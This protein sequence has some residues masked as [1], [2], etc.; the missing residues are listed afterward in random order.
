MNKIQKKNTYSHFTTGEFAKLCNVKKQTLFH[1]D[2][3]GIFSPEIKTNNGYRYYSYRQL[4]IFSVIS[5][6]KDLNMPLKDIKK[7]LDNRN[8]KALIDLLNEQEKE[9]NKKMEELEWMKGFINTKTQLTKAGLSAKSGEIYIEKSK[10]EYMIVSDYKGSENEKD[11]A[12]AIIKHLNFC[13]SVDVYS[14]HTIGG[15][16]PTTQIPEDLNYNYSHFYTKLSKTD[17]SHSSDTNLS[18]VISIKPAGNYAVIYHKGYD[19]IYNDYQN[20]A[21]YTKKHGLNIGPYF[22]EDIILDEL[23]MKG[24]ENYVIKLSLLVY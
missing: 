22:Y 1:Y 4:E 17:Y 18:S 16:I 14:A 8:P 3:I 20:L 6:L 13:H 7:Y 21:E 10:K 19:G 5:M 23:S 15:M 11:I 2:D 24:W 12:A 9:I